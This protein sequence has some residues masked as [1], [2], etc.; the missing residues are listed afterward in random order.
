MEEI[1]YRTTDYSMDNIIGN[2]REYIEWLVKEYLAKGTKISD[3]L[4][5]SAIE[6]LASSLRT[7]LQIEEHLTLA[8]EEAY[9]VVEKS[10]TAA[11]VESVL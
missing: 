9:Q 1:S 11:V 3:L 5:S 10:V 7:P 2:Q 4:D 6:L 8:F